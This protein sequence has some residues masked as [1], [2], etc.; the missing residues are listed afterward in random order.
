MFI[1][2][3]NASISPSATSNSP[4]Q[5]RVL[6]TSENPVAKLKLTTSTHKDT[7][8]I[9]LNNHLGTLILSD[10]LCNLVKTVFII[11]A[12]AYIQL[13]KTSLF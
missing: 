12:Q 7:V 9:Q 5:K 10:Y 6:Q 13:I 11:P 8:L 3:I 2:R 1:N 4:G